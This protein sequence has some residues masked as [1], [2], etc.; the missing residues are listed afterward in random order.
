MALTPNFEPPKP[1]K[2]PGYRRWGR[3]HEMTEFERWRRLERL[4][5]IGR[6]CEGDNGTCVTGAATRRIVYCD[7]D[8]ETKRASERKEVLSCSRHTK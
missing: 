4:D 8:P 1:P 3:W 7:L 6:R 2:P 5:K